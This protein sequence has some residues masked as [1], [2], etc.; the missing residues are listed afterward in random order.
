MYLI[1]KRLLDIFTSLISIVF[2]IIPWI[3]IVA[4]IKKKSPGPAIYKAVRIGKGGEEFI[5]YK[6]R[7]MNVNS[8]KIRITTL[9]NDE[10]VFGFGK[11]LR[12]TKLD[13]TPQLV[14]VLIGNMTLIGPRPEDKENAR[15]LYKGK[16]KEILT[17]RPG[18]SSPASLFD[19]THGE[20]YEN[21]YLYKTEFLPK[22]MELELYYI[23][24]RSFCYD[25]EIIF[26]TVSTII[27]K[28]FGKTKFKE[29]R[30]LC[31]CRKEY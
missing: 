22:K 9:T 20:D 7:S 3:I 17:V 6:F 1:C 12:K 13:E 21:E 27:M 29:P 8:G 14:N 24:K 23:K 15:I 2:L 25:I 19:Y 5:L 26:R 31:E 30:E 10:R 28:F 4:V 11:F 18:L 16:Y